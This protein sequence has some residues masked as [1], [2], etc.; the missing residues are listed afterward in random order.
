M[1]C[2]H[3]SFIECEATRQLNNKFDL[4]KKK[5]S[6]LFSMDTYSYNIYKRR[7]PWILETDQGE[8]HL[9]FPEET[10]EPV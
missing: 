7:F 10:F 2:M 6:A 9:F 1:H 5:L 4:S 8:F 3:R